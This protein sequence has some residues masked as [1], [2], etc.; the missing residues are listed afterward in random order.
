MLERLEVELGAD[1]GTGADGRDRDDSSAGHHS[2][3]RLVTGTRLMAVTAE[4]PFPGPVCPSGGRRVPARAGERGFAKGHRA[5][6][7]PGRW[8]DGGERACFFDEDR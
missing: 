2:R 7:A 6:A 5:G 3:A 1:G 4:T 8:G